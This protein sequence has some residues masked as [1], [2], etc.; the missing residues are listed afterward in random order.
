MLKAGV[1]GRLVESMLQ[2]IKEEGKF[3]DGDDFVSAREALSPKREAGESRLA[4]FDSPR[5][6]SCPQGERNRMLLRL[7]ANFPGYMTD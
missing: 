4:C 3:D 1:S 5:F 2:M 7:Y 6:K